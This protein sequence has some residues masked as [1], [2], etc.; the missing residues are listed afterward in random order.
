V[1]VLALRNVDELFHSVRRGWA[2]RVAH[3][4][5]DDVLSAAGGYFKLRG[6]TEDVRR[7]L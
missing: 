4:H 7:K 1:R 5:V 2:I 6:N 3:A